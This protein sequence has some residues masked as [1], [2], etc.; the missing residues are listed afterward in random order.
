M[1]RLRRRSAEEDLGAVE[2]ERVGGR[3]PRRRRGDRQRLATEGVVRATVLEVGLE[4]VAND[5]SAALVDG[6]VAAVEEP[7]Q[8]GA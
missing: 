5:E 3:M 4:A 7:V 1:N 2:G 8:V 6:Y